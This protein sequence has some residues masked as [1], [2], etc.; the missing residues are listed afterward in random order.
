MTKL[1][2]GKIRYP[3]HSWGVFA[4]HPHLEVGATGEVWAAAVRSAWIRSGGTEQTFEEMFPTLAE[5]AK[6]QPS[7]I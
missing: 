1:V 7:P 3:S 6:K 2:S 5:H 4:R